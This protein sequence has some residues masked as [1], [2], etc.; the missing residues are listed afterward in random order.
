MSYWKFKR[1]KLSEDWRNFTVDWVNWWHENGFLTFMFGPIIPF[2]LGVIVVSF[3]ELVRASLFL[4]A[5]IW[6]FLF[7]IYCI[8]SF[9]RDNFKEWKEKQVTLNDNQQ[10]R[11][12]KK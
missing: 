9:E 11:S 7:V 1:E 12:E 3:S 2:F 4:I 6:V 8:I 5:G 10:S